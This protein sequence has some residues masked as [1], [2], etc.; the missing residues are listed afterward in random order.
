M[1][2]SNS[3]SHSFLKG[4]KDFE[5]DDSVFDM[6]RNAAAKEENEEGSSDVLQLDIDLSSQ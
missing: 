2:S 5:K 6:I 4:M 1:Q 3:D